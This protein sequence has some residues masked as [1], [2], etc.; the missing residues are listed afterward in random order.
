MN[1]KRSALRRTTA[2]YDILAACMAVPLS[3]LGHIL[4]YLVRYGLAGSFHESHGAHAYFPSIAKASAGLVGLL[5]L[6]AVALVG[7]ARL[8]GARRVTGQRRSPAAALPELVAVLLPLQLAIFIAQETIELLAAGHLTGLGDVPLLW[9][10][11]GQ[12]PVALLAA[13]FLRW[14]SIAVERAIDRLRFSLDLVVAPRSL[15]AP[16]AAAPVP[17]VSWAA[18][19]DG[20]MAGRK[21]GPP[22]L[23]SAQ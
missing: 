18:A 6:V 1:T 23:S 4:V 7:L 17:V 11:A 19:A 22:R 9:G 20:S 8:V 5:V 12:L 3:Q 15:A 2:R 16:L 21:R 13:I 14:A 10:L